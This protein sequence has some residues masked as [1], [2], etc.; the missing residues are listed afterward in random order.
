MKQIKI[1]MKSKSQLKRSA[2][3]RQSSPTFEDYLT[4]RM[5]GKTTKQIQ[6]EKND[7]RRK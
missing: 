7:E 4:Q 2:L 6:N 5:L 1:T 3:I